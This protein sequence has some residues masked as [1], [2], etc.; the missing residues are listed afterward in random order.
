MVHTDTPL[1]RVICSLVSTSNEAAIPSGADLIHRERSRQIVEEGW[2]PQHDDQH[3]LFEL[4]DAAMCYAERASQCE[5]GDPW[6]EWK[7]R[8]PKEW[9]WSVKWWKPEP[10]LGQPNYEQAIRNLVKAGA[11]IAAEIDRLNRLLSVIDS[12]EGVRMGAGS[13]K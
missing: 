12:S 7:D 10:R 11:L 4:T 6:P 13:L 3:D 2:T 5:D 1:G 9:P 8:V